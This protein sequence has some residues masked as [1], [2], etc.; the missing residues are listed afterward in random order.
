MSLKNIGILNQ[1]WPEMDRTHDQQPRVQEYHRRQTETRIIYFEVDMVNFN[2]RHQPV[3]ANVLFKNLTLLF[4][5]QT[6]YE[7]LECY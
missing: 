4:V 7:L 3:L 2:S 1:A 6:L 5:G